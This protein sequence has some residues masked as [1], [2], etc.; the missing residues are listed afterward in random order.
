MLREKKKH[1]TKEKQLA[2]SLASKTGLKYETE[3]LSKILEEFYATVRTKDVEDYKCDSFHE[4][5]ITIDRYLT[6]KEEYKRL[7][8]LQINFKSLKQREKAWLLL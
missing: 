7:I 2:K 3:A 5:V 4:M 6:E 8:I 1:P